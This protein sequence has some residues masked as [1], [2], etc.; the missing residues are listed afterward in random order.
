[1]ETSTSRGPR[2]SGGGMSGDGSAAS[3][4]R[5]VAIHLP[6]LEVDLTVRRD[7]DGRESNP[8]TTRP[9]EEPAVIVFQERNGVRRVRDCCSRS[10]EAGVIPGMGV[11]EARALLGDGRLVSRL[12][13]PDRAARSLRRLAER[14]L[15]LA[16]IAAVDGP[17]GIV[18]DLRGCERWLA[19]RGGEPGLLDRLERGFAKAGFAVGT[20]IA[21]TVVMARAWCRHGSS[22]GTMPGSDGRI[23]PGG[24]DCSILDPLPIECLMF[25]PAIVDRLREVHVRTVG[26][27]R[28]LPRISLPSR[29]GPS[30]L[31]RLDQAA[32]RVNV[33]LEGVRCPKEIAVSRDFDG[34]VRSRETI[35]LAMV[36]LLATLHRSLERRSRGAR[37]LRLLAAMSNGMDWGETVELSGVTR[38]PARLWAV[39]EPVIGRI[40]LDHGVDRMGIE[41]R[42]HRR[43][44]GRTGRLQDGAAACSAE[45][46][47]ESRAAFV[48]LVQA[49]FGRETVHHFAPRPSHVPEDQNRTRQVAGGELLLGDRRS[50]TMDSLGDL[51]GV[52]EA[53]PTVWFERPPLV[54]VEEID[55]RPQVID[56]C[57]SRRRLLSVAGPETIGA[58]WWRVGCSDREAVRRRYWRVVPSEGSDLWIF[59]A[60]SDGRWYLQ[61]VWA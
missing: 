9:L 46:R 3:R 21:D 13:C 53:R 24:T 55:G 14:C 15:R 56:W 11:A 12:S 19:T 2:S 25:E 40:P 47:R 50:D 43:L 34:P 29:Y 5:F 31:H 1:M 52:P 41:V 26:Q 20:A 51:V 48:D 54:R 10:R 38:R 18:L 39:V 44:V 61:G 42:S 27:L 32:G 30:L 16:P 28:R 33:T 8:S 7:R 58:P 17:D 59:Q 36:D 35:E 23:L 45:E 49:R 37:R 6:H 57:G 22:G 4:S 60:S